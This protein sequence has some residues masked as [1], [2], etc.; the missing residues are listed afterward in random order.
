ME[1]IKNLL[2]QVAIIQKKYEEIAEYT[3]ER[4]N[5][6]DILGV[7]S[8]EL[9]HSAI[10][11][12]LLNTQ[13]KHGQKDVFLKLFI[14]QFSDYFS[15]GNRKTILK[16]F[17]TPSSSARKEV[18]HGK[19]NHQNEEG[20][21][22]DIV[23][24]D[25]KNNIIIENK[26]YAADQYL[27][28]KRYN[29]FDKHAPILYLTLD[30]KIPSKESSKDLTEKIEFVCLSYKDDIV[31]WLEKCIKEMA[32]KPIIR[33]TLNQYVHLIKSLTNQSNN[34]KMNEEILKLLVANRSNFTSSFQIMNLKDDLKLF[35]IKEIITKL[36]NK[37]EAEGFEIIEVLKFDNNKKGNLIS[38]TNDKMKSDNLSIRLN[39][40][41]SGY[42]NLI[43][44][45]YNT[46]E[47]VKRPVLFSKYKQLF[48]NAKENIDYPAYSEYKEYEMWWFTHLEKFLFDNDGYEMFEKDLFSK[49]NDHLKAL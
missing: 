11:A 35:M 26:I 16:N 10:I 47:K 18:Y 44:G 13:G 46:A 7:Q 3:G 27:Q 2:Q 30:R 36:S 38:F 32:N 45:F 4:Y 12:N 15:D 8:D 23:I 19:V 21:R 41:S 20:G 9:S 6:F 1:Q 49:I 33:E 22:I 31:N 17:N 48:N 37:L 40:E 5:V 43:I 42:G 29:D 25:G 34:S 24:Y 14:E 39:F 28:L